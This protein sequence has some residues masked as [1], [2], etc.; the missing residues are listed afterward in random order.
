MRPDNDSPQSPASL[1]RTASP[2]TDFDSNFGS[3]RVNLS[4]GS[5]VVQPELNKVTLF[6]AM[7][8]MVP[9]WPFVLRFA[10]SAAFN[11]AESY[12]IAQK[13][14]DFLGAY[15]AYQAANGLAIGMLYSSIFSVVTFMSAAKREE[16]EALKTGDQDAIV[17]ARE[18]VRVIWRQ[19]IVFATLL[20]IP[21][22]VFGLTASPMFQLFK[23]SD[24]ITDNS[25]LF[26][27][28]SAPGFVA[29][30]FYRLTARTVSGL[31]VRKSILVADGFDHLL[32]LGFSYAFLN[33]AAGMPALGLPGLGLAYSISKAITLLAHLLYMATSPRCLG[34]DYKRYHL[35][36]C[37]G[38][39]FNRDVFKKIVSAGIPDGVSNVFSA[40]SS[41][42]VVMFCGQLGNEPLVGMQIATIYSGFANFHMSAVLNAACNKIGQYN[43]ILIDEK[44]EFDHETKSAVVN[45]IKIYTKLLIAGCVMISTL[46]C[47]LALIVPRQLAGLLI[48][49]ENMAHQ[50][51]LAHAI[52]FLKIQGVFEL[53]NGFRAPAN[54][55]LEG[56]LDNRFLMVSTIALDLMINPVAAATARYGLNKDADWVYAA[57]GLGSLMMTI[58]FLWRCYTKLGVVGMENRLPLPA[59]EDEVTSRTSLASE[60]EASSVRAMVK[61][62][63]GRAR[64]LGGSKSTVDPSQPLL[65]PV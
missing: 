2:E 21:A 34:F 36:Q 10:V 35:F 42:L 16:D 11:A 20:S 54:C 44:N 18:K 46:A 17:A 9:F 51:H 57:S 60:R 59:R 27:L 64:A 37:E 53:M 25:K 1:E 47:G 48:D 13:E 24:V 65:T 26:M 23:Q 28:Y 43:D 40:I 14:L 12:V 7:K 55:V 33:G 22:V 49:E 41:M 3:T 63:A 45:N 62:L 32:E 6:Q 52:T 4:Q 15:A 8:E 39:F 29:D 50:G 19:G 56:F 38:Q 5:I 61:S 30:I 31:G 58:L